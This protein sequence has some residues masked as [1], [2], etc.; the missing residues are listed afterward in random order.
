MKRTRG[1]LG[2]QVLRCS[3]LTPGQRRCGSI[4]RDGHG[5]AAVQDDTGADAAAAVVADAA[6]VMLDTNKVLLTA[7]QRLRI[8][9]CF[10]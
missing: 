1:N 3:G 2:K 9:G 5:R 4:L 7:A 10:R 6:A 8:T